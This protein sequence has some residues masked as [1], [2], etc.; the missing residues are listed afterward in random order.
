MTNAFLPRGVGEFAV[1]RGRL[2]NPFPTF[3]SDQ[4]G[5]HAV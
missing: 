4:T 3:V 5:E 1:E 2:P